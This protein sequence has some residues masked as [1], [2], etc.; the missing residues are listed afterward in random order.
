MLEECDHLNG[1]HRLVCRGE[2][3][4]LSLK[5]TN[6]AR[7]RLW[8]LLPLESKSKATKQTV[9]H[10]ADN[11]T[12]TA[13]AGPGHEL[14]MIMK[15]KGVPS[16][17]RCIALANKMDEWG[18]EGCQE[19]IDLIVTD[20]LPRA[21]EWVKENHPFVTRLFTK[22]T[23]TK[24]KLE[25][26]LKTA[27]R[28][29]VSLA[30]KNHADKQKL[31]LFGELPIIKSQS[32][33]SYKN[34]VDPLIFTDKAK[35]PTNIFRDAVK[36]HVGFLV[37]GGPSAKQLDLRL[38]EQR[39]IWS[40]AVNN[41]AAY[42]KTSCFICADPPSKFSDA[43]WLDPNIIKFVPLAKL[44]RKKGKLR[45]KVGE[46]FETLKIDD[47]EITVLDCPNVWGFERRS[48]MQL[49][50]T[51]FTEP[52]AAWGNHEA[53]TIR[54]GRQKTVNTMLLA[55]RIMYAIGIRTLFLVGVDFD[56]S[57]TADPA[58]NYAFGE[59]RDSNAIKSNNSQY[60]IVNKWLCEMQETGVFQ[61][62]GLSIY[63]V[64]QN[65]NLRAFP[66]VPYELAIADALKN[67]PKQIELSNWYRK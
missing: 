56:M 51:F 9:K 62:F 65:S 32:N 1:Y 61:R 26:K 63:N 19:R 41:M 55:I 2:C 39:G 25:S 12:K 49:D 5:K 36:G 58:G 3:P 64:N 38:L 15:A 37:C 16:C 28:D 48:W 22:F 47:K 35:N 14:T 23:F 57:P 27:I 44:T 20:I 46:Q 40:M 4:H 50:D 66:Y 17:Q 34:H 29:L 33:M 54:T 30:I 43:I 53:G 45:R 10:I 42:V 52:S 13:K 18:V 24:N 11:A 60:E 59:L 6:I 67:F 7:K 8:N 21:E 31:P